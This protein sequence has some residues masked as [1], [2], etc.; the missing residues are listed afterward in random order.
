MNKPFTANC[1]GR[2]GKLYAVY[3]MVDEIEDAENIVDQCHLITDEAGV[4]Q[5]VSVE[6]EQ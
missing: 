1:L 4:C 5:M 2:D 3:F 6:G